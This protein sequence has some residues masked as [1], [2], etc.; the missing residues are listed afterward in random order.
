[1]P[2]NAADLCRTLESCFEQAEEQNEKDKETKKAKLDF[3]K[4]MYPGDQ[5]A[6]GEE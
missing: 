2:P 4:E 6:I 1:M 3:Q 5:A